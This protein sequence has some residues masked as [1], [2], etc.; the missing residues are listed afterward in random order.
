M[1]SDARDSEVHFVIVTGRPQRPAGFTVR[2]GD[3]NTGMLNAVSIEVNG[4]FDYALATPAPEGALDLRTL[5]THEIGHALGLAHSLSPSAVMRAG[6]KPGR[7]KHELHDDDR[8]GCA[9]LGFSA[10]GWR[11]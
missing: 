7:I 1:V 4:A 5:L 11:P 2:K 6:I 9:A 3:A 10:T 8:K